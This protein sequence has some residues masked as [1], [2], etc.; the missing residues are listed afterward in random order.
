MSE[1]ELIED[2]GILAGQVRKHHPRGRHEMPNVV[3]DVARAKEII[4]SSRLKPGRLDRSA[5][6]LAVVFVMPS[7]KWRY[8]EAAISFRLRGFPDLVAF[9]LRG[10]AAGAFPLLRS[11]ATGSSGWAS[12]SAAARERG[13]GF[14]AA[15]FVAMWQTLQ[16]HVENSLCA[17]HGADE[18]DEFL[19]QAPHHRRLQG[20]VS[21]RP[22][23]VKSKA[24]SIPTAGEL[25]SMRARICTSCMGAVLGYSTTSRR[26]S[27]RLHDLT[28]ARTIRG[29]D[30]SASIARMRLSRDDGCGLS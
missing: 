12:S 8:H 22:W 25:C 14:R 28:T 29:Q 5:K 26:F 4:R 27:R 23:R 7:T 11:L 2:I 10:F 30:A 13:A 18:A 1:T 21:L 9:A 24:P 6:D 17:T 19:S 16:E 20:R 3:N 15:R